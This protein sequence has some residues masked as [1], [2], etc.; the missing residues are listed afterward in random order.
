MA[1]FETA[2][3]LTLLEEGGFVHNTTTGEVA[4]RGITLKL[5]RSLGY[6]K[7][8]GPATQADLEFMQSLSLEGT[9]DIYEQEFWPPIMDAIEVQVVANKVFDLWVNTGHGVI[10]LQE[11]INKIIDIPLV[12]DGLLGPKTIVA[13][14][15]CAC[16]PDAVGLMGARTT[17]TVSGFGIRGFAEIY[18]RSIPDPCGALPDWLARLDK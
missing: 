15:I 1:L 12:I 7:S 5:V 10:F 3:A 9:K 17:P 16:P 14:N 18:Y 2:V 11:A 4:N 6:L 13:T 8:T